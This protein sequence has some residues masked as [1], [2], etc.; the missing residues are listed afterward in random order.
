MVLL[1]RTMACGLRRPRTRT[2]K[3]GTRSVGHPSG[4]LGVCVAAAACSIPSFVCLADVIRWMPGRVVIA[5]LT[6]LAPLAPREV[7]GNTANLHSLV[8][9]TMFWV[10]LYRPRTRM[11]GYLLGLLTVI[12]GL[13]EIQAV[14]LLLWRVRDRTL[15]WPRIGYL[16]AVGAQLVVTALWPRQPDNHPAVGFPSMAYGFII[17]SIVPVRI[18]QKLIGTALVWGGVPL[19][20]ALCLPLI[21]ALIVCVRFGSPSERATALGL[22][23]FAAVV[24]CASIYPIRP[25]K[26]ETFT[27]PC[28]A[29]ADRGDASDLRTTAGPCPRHGEG[30]LDWHV[31]IPCGRSD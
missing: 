12:G 30:T 27:R 24:Y 29:A 14:F 19:C 25:P 13:T 23:G 1:D 28:M 18:P 22:V 2:M 6:V 7:S 10:I 21:G 11:G 5:S 16:L 31:D 20:L 8:L 4:V 15:A 17:N 9:W 3:R 26:H